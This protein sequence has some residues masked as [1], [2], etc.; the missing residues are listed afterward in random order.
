MGRPKITV[1]GAGN[2]GE[3]RAAVGREG[4][5]TKSCSSTL[6]RDTPGKALDITQA[7]PVCGLQHQSCRDER[8]RRDQGRPSP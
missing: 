7:G 6:S 2:V 1:V 4:M 5:R 3:R 8:L